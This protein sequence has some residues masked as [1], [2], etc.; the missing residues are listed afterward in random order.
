M[1]DEILG[2]KLLCELKATAA[3]DFFKGT[4]RDCLVSF[5]LR[6]LSEARREKQR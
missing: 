6:L 3:K 2:V 4:F 1:I 5:E